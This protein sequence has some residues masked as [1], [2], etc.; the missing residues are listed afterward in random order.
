LAAKKGYSL[1]ISLLLNKPGIG[2]NE[3]DKLKNTPLHYASKHGYEEIVGKLLEMNDILINEKNQEGATPLYFACRENHL[4]IATQLK[5][6][7]GIQINEKNKELWTPLHAAVRVKN[8]QMIQMLLDAPSIMINEQTNEGLTPLHMAVREEVKCI[9]A[10]RLLLNQNGIEVNALTY[11]LCT[12]PLC[13]AVVTG[14]LPI[15]TLLLS[16]EAIKENINLK[17]INHRTPLH[18]AAEKGHESI[19]RLLLEN[20]A[21]VNIKD[22]NWNKPSDL[23]AN[24]ALKAELKRK[25]GFCSLQ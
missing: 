22:K 8:S 10:V 5:N 11:Q 19:V 15:V 16:N 13:L 17:N 25:E 24:K 1:I 12:T 7:N 20:G 4:G 23:V 6:K 21:N 2:I 14:D 18:Y 3:I 9:D